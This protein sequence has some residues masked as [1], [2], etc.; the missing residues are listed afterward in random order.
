MDIVSLGRKINSARKAMG[1]TGEAL[2]EKCSINPT[3]LRQL[4]GGTKTPSLPLFVTLCRVLNASPSYLL[5]AD[6][7]VDAPCDPERLMNLL[8]SLPPDKTE[9]VIKLFEE[10]AEVIIY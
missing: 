5:S 2:A 10:L 4:E 9:S 6:V 1:I 3:Y 8:E 7:K